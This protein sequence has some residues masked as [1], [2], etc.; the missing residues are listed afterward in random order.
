MK[1]DPEEFAADFDR[2]VTLPATLRLRSENELLDREIEDI[3][4]RLERTILRIRSI[5]PNSA[6]NKETAELSGIY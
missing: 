5:K 3:Q 6:A 1:V 2:R 4:N